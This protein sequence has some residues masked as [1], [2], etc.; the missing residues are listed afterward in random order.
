MTEDIKGFGY[1]TTVLSGFN[2][3]GVEV[4]SLQPE[5]GQT[6]PSEMGVM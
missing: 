1:L 6:S 2:D 3:Q 4:L 5:C